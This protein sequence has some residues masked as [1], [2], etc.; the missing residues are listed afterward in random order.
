MTSLLGPL[1]P[2]GGISAAAEAAALPPIVS[3]PSSDA[4]GTAGQHAQQ[5]I[6]QRT[7]ARQPMNAVSLD[8]LS[9]MLH[10][11]DEV[12]LFPGEEEDEQYQEFL[13]V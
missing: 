9:A 5:A 2:P 3:L 10:V 11:D 13:K 12:E 1:S 7:R 4:T 8:E 6:W